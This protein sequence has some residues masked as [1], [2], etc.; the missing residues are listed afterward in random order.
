MFDRIKHHCTVIKIN[1]P[2][3]R[4]P[5]TTIDLLKIKKATKRHTKINQQVIIKK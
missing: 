1:S 4:E 3:L 5:Q 2:S